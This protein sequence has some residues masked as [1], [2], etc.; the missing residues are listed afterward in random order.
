MEATNQQP[1][2]PAAWCNYKTC[3]KAALWLVYSSY[4]VWSFVKQ[5]SKSLDSDTVRTVDLVLSI[6]LLVL[7][8][9]AMSIDKYQLTSL[10]EALP[11]SDRQIFDKIVSLSDRVDSIASWSVATGHSAGTAVASEPIAEEDNGDLTRRELKVNNKTFTL[12]FPRVKH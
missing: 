10:R 4:A 11:E 9:F 5:Q 1:T 12:Q 2:K 3:Q 8:K 7:L 6:I